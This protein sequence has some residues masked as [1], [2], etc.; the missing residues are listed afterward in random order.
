MDSWGRSGSAD[1]R[2]RSV[3]FWNGAGSGVEKSQILQ[4]QNEERD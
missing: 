4:Y 2:G 3:S 1:A